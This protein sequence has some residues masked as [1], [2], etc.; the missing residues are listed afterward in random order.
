MLEVQGLGI[1]LH[2]AVIGVDCCWGCACGVLQSCCACRAGKSVMSV[3]KSVTRL[4]LER[5]VC[6]AGPRCA[7]YCRACRS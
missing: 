4:C 7:A 6:C 1:A 5:M 3:M 2:L